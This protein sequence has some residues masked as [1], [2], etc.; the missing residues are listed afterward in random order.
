MHANGGHDQLDGLRLNAC[1]AWKSC[2]HKIW[3]G[4]SSTGPWPSATCTGHAGSSFLG[5]VNTYHRT[6]PC[7]LL[8]CSACMSNTLVRVATHKLCCCWLLVRSEV[9]LRCA[10]DR[11]QRLRLCVF[12]RASVCFMDLLPQPVPK[13]INQATGTDE[14]RE[15]VSGR[16]MLTP[17][18]HSRRVGGNMRKPSWTQSTAARQST[19]VLRRASGSP[20]AGA[21]SNTW[22]IHK[23]PSLRALGPRNVDIFS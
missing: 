9:C 4:L 17:V 23:G 18:A 7:A 2:Q 12:Q 11:L 6:S 20:P 15:R 13:D 1:I 19:A 14:A 5:H 22:L 8:W 16:S 10:G 21:P 3:T